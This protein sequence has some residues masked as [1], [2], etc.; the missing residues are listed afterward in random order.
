MISN[1][2]KIKEIIAYFSWIESMVKINNDFAYTDINI[3][4]ETFIL[5]LMKIV[6]IGDYENRNIK[7]V[8]YPC[9]DLIDNNSN[10][11][12]QITSETNSKKIKDTLDKNP[13]LKIKFFFLESSYKPRQKTF[14]QYTNFSVENDIMN[15]EKIVKILYDDESKIDTMLKFLKDNIVLPIDTTKIKTIFKGYSK[16]QQEIILKDISNVCEKFVPTNIT[17]KC[18]EH[19]EEKNLLILIGNPGVG[20]SY[21]SKFLVAKYIEKGYKLLYS[22]NKNLKD[23]LN[24][25]NDEDKFVLF[26]DDIFGSNNLDFMATLSDSEITSLLENSNKNIKIIINSRTSLFNDA[27]QKYDK[28][29]RLGLKPFIIETANFSHSEKARILIKHLKNSKIPQKFIYSLFEKGNYYI[30]GISNRLNIYRIIYHKNYNPRIIEQMTSIDIIPSTDNYIETIINNLDNP[31]LIYNHPYVNNLDENERTIIKII[32][33]KSTY[34]NNYEVDIEQ[35]C[36]IVSNLGISEEQFEIS[37]RKLE[38]SFISLYNKSGRRVCK[39]YDPSVMDYCICKFKESSDME[40]L[41]NFVN[42]GEELD[43]VLLNSKI[44]F[45]NKKKKIIDLNYSNFKVLKELEKEIVNDDEI[46]NYIKDKIFDIKHYFS[47][48]EDYFCKEQ[49]IS[50]KEMLDKLFEIDKFEKYISCSI[51]GINNNITKIILKN[52]NNFTLERQDNIIDCC[53]TE[54]NDVLDYEIR[55]YIDSQNSKEDCKE[56]IL[57]KEYENNKDYII[58]Q[59]NLEDISKSLIY[60]VEINIKTFDIDEF[61]SYIDDTF[62]VKK[63]EEKIDYDT[64]ETINIVEEFY[65]SKIN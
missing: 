19:L 7:K 10:I 61:V 35:L 55:S 52:F 59:L 11:G 60:A 12:L 24:E 4:I 23:I 29:G 5:K 65:Q 21:N 49:F 16:Y 48:D 39:F 40:R 36:K 37:L 9:I 15:F 41:I 34:K 27:N 54:I 13:K 45:K 64:M 20:K 30:S 18:L 53:I 3:S 50:E 63:D 28:I 33:L 25:Y 56:D 51:T 47:Y 42:V 26:I 8:N 38:K 43:N 22:P 62:T 6:D 58:E 57:K 14:Q 31:H 1:E 32:Y 2:S 46:C 44:D 17:S